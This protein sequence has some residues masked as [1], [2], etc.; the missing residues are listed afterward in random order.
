MPQLSRQAFLLFVLEDFSQEDA[1]EVLQISPAEFDRVLV[2]AMAEVS[3]HIATTVLIIEDEFSDTVDLEKIL[4]DLGHSVF[5]M[6]STHAQALSV[7]EDKKPGLILVDIENTVCGNKMLE[8]VD[9]IITKDMKPIAIV[10]AC[11]K[12]H[13]TDLRRQPNFLIFKPF[14]QRVVQGVINQALF[15]QDVAGPV[16]DKPQ[17]ARSML[18]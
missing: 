2:E 12:A 10:A 17:Q 1:A 5:K 16:S 3:A 14:E 8:T 15:F 9:E 13:L 7:I 6:P 4:H 11:R 18:G